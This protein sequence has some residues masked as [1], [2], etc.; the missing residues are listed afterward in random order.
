[1]KTT[2]IKL[3]ICNCLKMAV[4]LFLHLKIHTPRLV[5]YLLLFLEKVL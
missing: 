2:E 1:M 4:C 3:M 5:S